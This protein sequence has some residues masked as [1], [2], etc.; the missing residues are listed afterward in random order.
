MKYVYNISEKSTG[1]FFTIQS[2]SR[3]LVSMSLMTRDPLTMGFVNNILVS[4]TYCKSLSV[5]QWNTLYTRFRYNDSVVSR[6]K[7]DPEKVRIA[8][9]ALDVMKHHAT[10]LEGSFSWKEPA[11]YQ[12]YEECEGD[13]G[14]AW[15]DTGM[16]FSADYLFETFSIS[17]LVFLLSFLFLA[18]LLN[19]SST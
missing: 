14:L 8:L 15:K 19:E 16:L 5:C 11:C 13:Q 1:W 17:V 3:Q 2:N 4:P 9:K 18:S 7:E 10:S 12:D 6:F